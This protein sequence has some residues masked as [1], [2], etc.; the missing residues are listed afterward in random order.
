MYEMYINLFKPNNCLL[1]TQ[2]LIPRRFGLSRFHCV[3]TKFSY[4]DVDQKSESLITGLKYLTVPNGSIKI[5]M[6]LC[7]DILEY[8]WFNLLKYIHKHKQLFY[9]VLI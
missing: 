3:F 2:K 6:F 1:R 7:L 8:I 9:K 4:F 5:A